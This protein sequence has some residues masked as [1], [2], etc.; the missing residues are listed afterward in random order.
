MPQCR[1]RGISNGKPLFS[2]CFCFPL[3]WKNNMFSPIPSSTSTFGNWVMTRCQ[4]PQQN[5][6]FLSPLL[7]RQKPPWPAEST[8]W[9]FTCSQ[10]VLPQRHLPALSAGSREGLAFITA[11]PGAHPRGFLSAVPIT[12][13]AVQLKLLCHT[14]VFGLCRS[15]GKKKPQTNGVDSFSPDRKMISQRQ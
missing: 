9:L 10:C 15:G 6:S 1:S 13:T 12:R 4:N 14:F 11:L 3:Q 5:T 7:S 8:R 2:P